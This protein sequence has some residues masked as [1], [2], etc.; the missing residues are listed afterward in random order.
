MVPQ[1][2]TIEV[3][4]S[5]DT[6]TKDQNRDMDGNEDEDGDD[7]YVEYEGGDDFVPLNAS[8]VSNAS[9]TFQHEVLIPPQTHQHQ[10]PTLTPQQQQQQ[11]QHNSVVHLHRDGSIEIQVSPPTQSSVRDNSGRSM[12]GGR[13]SGGGGGWKKVD[14]SESPF[15]VRDIAMPSSNK[16]I[17]QAAEGT[18]GMEGTEGLPDMRFDLSTDSS[19]MISDVDVSEEWIDPTALNVNQ[20]VEAE[21]GTENQRDVGAS[22]LGGMSS[23]RR[24]GALEETTTTASIF[25]TTPTPNNPAEEML[26]LGESSGDMSRSAMGEPLV[27]RE[28]SGLNYSLGA[29]AHRLQQMLT[30]Q[31]KDVLQ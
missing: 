16:T 8:N 29:Q 17:K 21:S 30:E 24:D 9:H 25:V 23:T 5:M 2:I 28:E 1:Q 15:L 14:R 18:E 6:S 7:E 11:R 27:L 22:I 20:E 12:S 4:S 10:H 26:D 3:T 13:S 19:E 31:T